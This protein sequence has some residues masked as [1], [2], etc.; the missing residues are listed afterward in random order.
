M[1]AKQPSGAG[2]I[3]VVVG[4]LSACS[5][6]NST[7]LT[8]PEGTPGSIC[9][10][11]AALPCA[12]AN[13]VAALEAGQMGCSQQAPAYQALLDCLQGATFVCEQGVPNTSSC[14]AEGIQV[15]SCAQVGGLTAQND[16]TNAGS[17]ASV[18]AKLEALPCA[19]ANCVGALE[20]QQAACSGEAAAY[21]SLL[22][23]LQD[24]TFVCEGGMPNTTSCLA[25]ATP[26]TACA[27]S[28]VP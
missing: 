16:D 15:E 21:Q 5:G 26:V 25:E 28:G 12:P 17:P 11:L 13:C 14:L 1:R 23:C 7:G 27:Q 18:C 2:L 3:F 8:N 24:A 9:A 19:P 10:K 20:G 6:S 22:D 4:V